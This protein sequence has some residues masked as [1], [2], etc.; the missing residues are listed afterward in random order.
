[1]KFNYYK[2]TAKL[3]SSVNFCHFWKQTLQSCFFCFSFF[4]GALS[5]PVLCSGSLTFVHANMQRAWSR[6]AD[7]LL[8]PTYNLLSSSTLLRRVVT[9]ESKSKLSVQIQSWWDAHVDGHLH[10]I[11]WTPASSTNLEIL[12]TFF[13]HCLLRCK[14]NFDILCIKK[15]W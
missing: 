13:I 9:W 4:G 14:V 2:F 7:A 8:S 12:R 11:A 1:M 10:L 15:S 6:Q 3:R 5:L